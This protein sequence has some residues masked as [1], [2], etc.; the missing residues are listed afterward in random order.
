MKTKIRPIFFI[1]HYASSPKVGSL[2]SSTVS[3]LGPF[4]SMGTPA[5]SYICLA[6]YSQESGPL[7]H[8]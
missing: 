1:F 3:Q 2:H 4:A 5:I 7:A 6:R 8:T